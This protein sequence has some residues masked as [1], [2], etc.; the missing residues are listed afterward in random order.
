MLPRVHD[1]KWRVLFSQTREAAVDLSSQGVQAIRDFYN[2]SRSN[3]KS[4]K[5]LN[6]VSVCDEVLLGDNLA[7]EIIESHERRS[8]VG[9]GAGAGEG[10]ER[11]SLFHQYRDWGHEDVL[12]I[13]S[14]VGGTTW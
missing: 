3:R 7:I 11:E 10:R 1:L 14:G 2:F 4:Q 8:G 5:R 12:E 13:D 6:S 9:S